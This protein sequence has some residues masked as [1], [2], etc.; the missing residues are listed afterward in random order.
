MSLVLYFPNLSVKIF[1]S[2]EVAGSYGE[3]GALEIHR[4]CLTLPV[5]LRDLLVHTACGKDNSIDKENN[6]SLI[7]KDHS[8]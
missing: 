2:P 4:Q 3:K 7:I 1:L 5:L 6:C 8:P